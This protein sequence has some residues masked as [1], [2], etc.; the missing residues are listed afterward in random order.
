MSPTT[1]VLSMS[2][3]HAAGRG[4]RF[5][6][7]GAVSGREAELPW[8]GSVAPVRRMMAPGMTA[9]DSEGAGARHAIQ[10][11][12]SDAGLQPEEIGVINWPHVFGTPLNDATECLL[13]RTCFLLRADWSSPPKGNFGAQSSGPW[14]R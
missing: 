10:R 8:H 9:P 7:L 5:L 13:F 12:L 2:V 6:V 4:A 11:S 3:T 1:C 14:G